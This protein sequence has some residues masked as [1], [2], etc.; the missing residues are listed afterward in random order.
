MRTRGTVSQWNDERGFGFITP[1]GG[2]RRAF[3]HVSA[4]PRGRRLAVGDVVDYTAGSDESGRPRA[5]DVTVA[6]GHPAATGIRGDVVASVVVSCAF[7]VLVSVLVV[8]ATLHAAA[9]VVYGVLSLL[10]LGFYTADKDAARTGARRVPEQSLHLVD[11]LGG[12][13]GGLVARHVLRHKTRKQPF[14]AVF[15]VTVLVNCALFVLV[16]VAGPTMWDGLLRA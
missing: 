2:G 6:T 7:L 15:W 3:V 1:D 11:V 10:S 14:R 4:L 13:P 8:T 12:W 5:V 16:T 9:L